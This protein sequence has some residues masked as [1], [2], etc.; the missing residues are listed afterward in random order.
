MTV[1]VT[2]LDRRSPAALRAFV[3]SQR[4]RVERH[5]DSVDPATP[6]DRDYWRY[7]LR[8]V[9]LEGDCVYYQTYDAW[10]DENDWN[11]NIAPDASHRWMLDPGILYALSLS[12][13]APDPIDLSKVKSY[14]G[15]PAIECEL[16]P[17]DAL[18]DTFVTAGLPITSGGTWPDKDEQQG[19]GPTG[20]RVGVY[21]VFAGDYGHGGRPEIHPFDALW[22][23]FHAPTSSTISWDLGV[24]QDDSNRFNSD[25]SRAPIDIEFKVPFCVDIPVTLRT[26]TTR[27]VTFSLRRSPLCSVVGKHARAGGTAAVSE[28]FT[29]P[30]VRLNRQLR[31]RLLVSI[32]DR[33]DLPGRPFTLRFDDLTYTTTRRF[34]GFVTQAWLAGVIAIRVAV[35]QDGF[36]YWNLRGPNSVTAA[37]APSDGGTVIDP[38]VVVAELIKTGDARKRPAG[39]EVTEARSVVTIGD[40]PRHSAEVVVG[41]P[42]VGGGFAHHTLTVNPRETPLLIDDASGETIE[43][44]SFDVFAYA[45]LPEPGGGSRQMEADITAS[46]AR[47]AGIRPSYKALRRTSAAIEMDDFVIVDLAARYAPYRDGVVFGEERSKLAEAVNR[48]ESGPVDIRADVRFVGERDGVRRRRIAN[49]QA[50]T[51]SDAPEV[52]LDEQGNGYRLTVGPL[53]EPTSVRVEATLVDRFGLAADTRVSA[54]NYRVFDARAWVERAAAI[55]LSQIEARHNGIETAARMA[56]T[57][58]LV[59]S[60]A[61][62]RALIDTLASLDGPDA[63]PA[64]RVAGALRL[65][66]RVAELLP[67]NHAIEISRQLVSASSGR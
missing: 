4:L 17:D 45:S 39:L 5:P 22:R 66:V 7:L 20:E 67:T 12:S 28:T 26:A 18:Y 8:R 19:S 16:T 15:I 60:A 44:E 49:A 36:A 57:A 6:S 10:G 3:G 61:M 23:R 48:A 62:L 64:S 52:H 25:W 33:T 59:S 58:D 2:S 1:D 41:G 31:N 43:M 40:T 14:Q 29:A 56:P 53:G 54:H 32:E 50:G 9:P 47:L 34:P 11:L 13:G 37:A 63:V 65:A 30:T 46:I 21:G 35:D 51:I 42:L 27:R 38:E 24:F 55:S